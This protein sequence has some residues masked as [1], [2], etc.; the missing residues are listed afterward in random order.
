MSW[1]AASITGI[2][3]DFEWAAV[4]DRLEGEAIAGDQGWGPV[5]AG[6]SRRYTVAE[7]KFCAT[8]WQN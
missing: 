4:E 8:Q 5:R 2:T 6:K 7:L 1:P 3:R